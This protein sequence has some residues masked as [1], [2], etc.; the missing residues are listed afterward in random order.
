MKNFKILIRNATEH[1]Y[2]SI[3]FL[4]RK[5]YE[6]YHNNIPNDYKKPPTPTLP[7][8]TFL[9]ILEDKNALLLIAESDKKVIGILY[10]MI[11][12]YEEDDWSQSYNRVSIEEMSVLKDFSRQG[13]GS[14]L[15][16]KVETWAKEKGIVDLVVLVHAFNQNAINFYA[17]NDFKSYSIKMT[18][19]ISKK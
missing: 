19:K 9:N 6:L 8:G 1:D 5:N 3:D 14:K 17:K 12:K 7:R 13:I 16:K 15:I 2:K 11:E 18:K 10:A 4:Y